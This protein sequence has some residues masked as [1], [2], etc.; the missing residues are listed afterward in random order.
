MPPADRR[1]PRGAGPRRSRARAWVFVLT[2]IL[3]VTGLSVLASRTAWQ[4][5]LNNAAADP[6]NASRAASPSAAAVPPVARDDRNY[7]APTVATPRVPPPQ[8][9]A[10]PPR[11]F[12]LSFDDCGPEAQVRAIIA[13]AQSKHLNAVFFPTGQCR[14]LNPW[15]VPL[16]QK[17]GFLACN[18]TYSHPDLRTISDADVRFQIANGVNT[19]CHYLRPPFGG[20]DA[21]IGRIANSMGYTLYDW[22][23]DSGDWT[24]AS[25]S[26]MVARI[27]SSHG[28]VLMHMH[29]THTLEALEQL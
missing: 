26:L 23:M 9:T 4:T 15:L 10:A 3:V 22:D 5:S 8:A 29:G 27:R 24:G 18:H 20:Q 11:P 13:V 14:D 1:R 19:G 12:V 7:R 17:S 16:I 28:I 2:A 25:A 6:T 21:R